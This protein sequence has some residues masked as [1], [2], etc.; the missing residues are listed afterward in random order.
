LYPRYQWFK[1]VV[2]VFEDSGRAVPIFNDKHLS[3]SW[4]ECVEM[5]ENSRRLRFPFMAGSSLPVTWRIPSIDLPLNTPLQESV[6]LGYGGVDSYDFHGLETA[7]CMS[8]RRAGGETGVKSVQALRGG[9]VWDQ[10]QKSDVTQKLV[11]AALLRSHT[12]R[13]RPGYTYALPDIAW[14]REGC[15]EA[16]G[17]FIEHRDGLKTTML[18]LNGFIDDFTYAGLVRDTGK[19]ISCQMYLPMPPRYTTLA[20]FFNPLMH[21]IEQMVL[22]GRVPYPVERTLLTSG[23]TLSAVESLHRQGTCVE[24]PQMAISYHPSRDSTFWRS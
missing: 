12:A 16:I 11:L 13:G 21:H 24:T 10:V 6:C 19:I 7:Q 14:L 1:R 17:Y 18:L 5:V 4:P 15:P 23:M 8:E 22:T 2:K 20:D 3:T 9:K